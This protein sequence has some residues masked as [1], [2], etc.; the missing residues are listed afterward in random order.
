MIE[1]VT[2]TEC[3]TATRDLAA[4]IEHVKEVAKGVAHNV[5]DAASYVRQKAESA[6][7]AVGGAMEDSGH[8]LRDDGINK[9]A[10]DLTNL[11]R[12][13]PLTSVLAGVAVGIL[14]ARSTQRR[15]HSSPRGGDIHA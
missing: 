15:S 2:E 11:V 5:S 12:R 4:G 9:I 3:R 7:T 8:Y 10:N 6:T 14:L 1:T 13:N